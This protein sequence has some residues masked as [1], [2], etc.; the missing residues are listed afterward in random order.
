MFNIFKKKPEETTG[1]VESAP[2]IE[3]TPEIKSE[4]AIKHSALKK[5]I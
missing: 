1:K 5:S 2:P 3:T 4:P